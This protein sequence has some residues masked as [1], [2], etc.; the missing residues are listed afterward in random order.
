[1]V[2]PI[3]TP[4]AGPTTNPSSSDEFQKLLE[5]GRTRLAR[6]LSQGP[7]G[8]EKFRDIMDLIGASQQGGDTLRAARDK[9][10]D[11]R[12]TETTNLQNFITH[13]DTASLNRDAE[14]R[15][16]GTQIYNELKD[17]RSSI[18]DAVD[19]Y[20]DSEEHKSQLMMDFVTLVNA[21]GIDPDEMPPEKVNQVMAYVRQQGD[22]AGSYPGDPLEI[23]RAVTGQEATDLGLDPEKHYEVT[24]V[25]E[26]DDKYIKNISQLGAG[27]NT[28]NIGAMEKELGK[29]LGKSAGELLTSTIESGLNTHQEKVHWDRIRIS[30]ESGNF[31]TGF[32]ANP[33]M[34]AANAA[35]FFAPQLMR[36]ENFI[37]WIGDDAT[38]EQIDA[39]VNL[40][41]DKM[42]GAAGGRMSIPRIKMIM[43][44]LPALTKSI[45]GNT[46][47]VKVMIKI[48]E[49]RKAV[50]KIA[51][52]Y[53]QFQ[54]MK[55]EGEK[56]FYDEVEQYYIDN[57][58]IDE[59]L[60]KLMRNLVSTAPRS[61][62]DV[63]DSAEIPGWVPPGA[64]PTDRTHNGKQ[65][66]HHGPSNTDHVAPD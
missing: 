13:E 55:P 30:L 47:L 33:R 44:S 3:S 65:V 45:A 56:G 28:F 58:V 37:T 35:R 5:Q 42:A 21:L 54:D 62:Q 6:G 50:G 64:I 41:A 27:G 39:A 63:L 10:K 60:D 17:Q 20:A 32:G 12:Q 36:D 18:T 14:K 23:A 40:I 2:T 38:G 11:Y 25:G 16:Q 51:Q 66:W 59:D 46:V 57:P 15:L 52:K 7:T 26:G 29:T 9:Q 22:L 8:G 4:S 24:E 48:L 1:M 19:R 34:W 61:F 31:T 49:A 53:A 43:N